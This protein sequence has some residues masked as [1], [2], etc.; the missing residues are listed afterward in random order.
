MKKGQTAKPLSL[1]MCVQ[2]TPL[3]H[4]SINHIS[5]NQREAESKQSVKAFCAATHTH[6]QNPADVSKS[7]R[8]QSQSK[9]WHL[10]STVE[11]LI[12]FLIIKKSVI[13]SGM[14]KAAFY[15]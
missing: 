13:H 5:T 9:K 6:T 10:F 12:G 14:N 7:I 4:W 11:T 15:I 8:L 1:L 3:P 2:T